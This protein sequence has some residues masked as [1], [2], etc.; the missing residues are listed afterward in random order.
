MDF[1]LATVISLNMIFQRKTGL[2]VFFT[3]IAFIIVCCVLSN[4]VIGNESL[5]D[6]FTNIK[7]VNVRLR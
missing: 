3:V 4:A 7:Q 2:F 1:L 5:I 6:E